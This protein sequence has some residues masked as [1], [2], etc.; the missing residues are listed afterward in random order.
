MVPEVWSNSVPAYDG[1]VEEGKVI[2]AG[3]TFANGGEEGWWIPQYL[4]DKHPELAT[5]EG[6]LANP[7]LVGARFHNCPVGWGCRIVNDNLKVVHDLEG[8]GI[9]VFDHGSGA[10][11]AASI[12]AAFEDQAPWFGYYWGPTAILGKY[13]MVKVDLGGVNPEQHRL[14]QV[15]GQDAGKIGVSDFPAAPVLTAM[16]ADFANRAPAAAEFIKNSALPNDLISAM[17]AWKEENNASADETAAWVLTNHTDVVM[18]MVS[19]EAKANL[20]KLF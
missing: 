17:L 5:L 15:E 7:E 12:A 18:S 13:P 4:A 8:N 11:L 19:G 3:N 9:E 1:L 20:E 10:N 14:N 2:T 6:V 16:T